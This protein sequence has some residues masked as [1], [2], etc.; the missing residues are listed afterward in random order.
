[1]EG[2][3]INAIKEIIFYGLIGRFVN[4]WE[5]IFVWE[6]DNPPRNEWGV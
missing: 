6:N 1:M 5:I 2:L 3:T 4:V